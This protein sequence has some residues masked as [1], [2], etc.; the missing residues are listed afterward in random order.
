MLPKYKY[1]TIALGIIVF[2]VT[3]FILFS[4]S[5]QATSHCPQPPPP[6]DPAFW[7]DKPGYCAIV[8]DNQPIKVFSFPFVD[9]I[10]I[11]LYAEGGS[12]GFCYSIASGLKP[13]NPTQSPLEFRKNWDSTQV[14][15]YDK[16]WIVVE[17]YFDPEEKMHANGAF[18]PISTSN[19]QTGTLCE[20]PDAPSGGDE[21]PPSNGDEPS[22]PTT[23]QTTQQT[24]SQTT[25]T[26]TAEEK[27]EKKD[28][29]GDVEEL[30]IEEIPITIDTFDPDIFLR[31]GKVSLNDVKN[32]TKD[33]VTT[34]NFQGTAEPNKLVTL[35]IFTEATVA[36]VRS[37]EQGNW[38]Y[39]L[40][41]PISTGKHIAFATVNDENV[42]RR[43]NVAEFFIAK[44]TQEGKSLLLVKSGFQRF[45]PYA[46]ALGVAVFLS[47]SI[48]A[49]YRIYN[50]RKVARA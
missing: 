11:N 35:Y 3:G 5:S 50:K 37:D 25:T 22:Q 29:G 38:A 28:E 33:G 47:I 7:I 43:S 45:Y 13:I 44:S 8:K 31:G 4:N 30:V 21:P 42:T 12:A 49:L 41:K 6:S 9:H 39:S 2:L 15:D 32:T 10:N 40:D 20:E 19:G 23:S 34:L 48:L 1:L 27:E 26:Q 18:R 17:A 46:A 16:Y 14:V 24:S 36:V